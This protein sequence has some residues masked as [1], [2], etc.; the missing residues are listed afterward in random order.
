MTAVLIG[1]MALFVL[2]SGLFSGSETALFSLSSMQLRAYRRELDP[3]KRLIARLM[4]RPRGLLVT[5][6]MGNVL[7]NIL[8]QNVASSLFGTTSAWLLTVGVPLGLTLV[9]G[10]LLPKTVALANNEQIARWVVPFIAFLHQLL[11]PIRRAITAIAGY[12]SQVTFFCLKPRKEISQEEL[13]HALDLSERHGILTREESELI[14]GTLAFQQAHVKELMRPRGDLILYDREEPVENLAEAFVEQ[15][16]TRVPVCHGDLEH[17]VGIIEATDFLLQRERI[18]S[19]KDVVRI[20]RKPLFVPETMPAKALLQKFNEGGGAMAIVVDEY[21]SATGLV[22]REDLV[23]VVVGE[24]AD[25]RDTQ[26]LYTRAGPDVVIASGKLE[27]TELRELFGVTLP[28]PRSLV[29]IGGWLADRIGSLPQAGAR[30]I[31]SDLLFQIL[32]ADPNRI[33]RVYIRRIR[34]P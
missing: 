24:I 8:V 22:T 18:Q 16:C 15:Q 9:F 26:T 20:S 2:L 25:Q 1:A 30:H 21:G 3:K 17:V 23:E 33:R 19:G 28:N 34:S 14:R 11:S 5:I 27:L 29:T 4:S 12:V 32:A 7:V 10:E 13:G 6:L 31:E